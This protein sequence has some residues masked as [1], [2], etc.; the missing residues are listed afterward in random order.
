[1]V[2]RLRKVYVEPTTRCNLNCRTCMRRAWDEPAADMSMETYHRLLDSL[3]NLKTVER[4]AYWGIGEALMHPRIAEM[5]GRA[6]AMGLETELITNAQLLDE[7]AARALV[8]AGL[9]RLIV[10]VDGTTT[11]GLSEIRPGAALET[12]RAN[13][14]FLRQLRG[15]CGERTPEIAVEFVL[16]RKNL[17]QLRDLPRLA[18]E[19]GATT[20]Y[21]T[22]VLPYSREL[23][24][25]IL[26]ALSATSEGFSIR[27]DHHD[28]FVFP[29]IDARPEMLA[30]IRTLPVTAHGDFG[31][32]LF[33]F[34]NDGIACPFLERGAVVVRWDGAVSPCVEL[35]HSHQVYVLGREKYVKS[36]VV[37]RLAEQ[38]LK[39]IWQGRGYR[40]FRE[41]LRRF[42]FSPCVGCGGCYMSE[43]NE[44]DCIG[45]TFP[46][47]GDCLWARRV[48]LCP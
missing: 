41:R 31:H 1:M 20:V 16:M 25:E 27:F 28:G 33:L 26:Y 34:G 9:D 36:H 5:I 18:R 13:I 14:G 45:S 35:L 11:A 21:L 17:D 23:S 2:H 40:R 39:E 7:S 15:D 47:C 6:H 29:R 32:S 30:A 8:D 46:T 44:E 38:T 22:N 48:V 19:L 43:S 3:R 42:E 10:S 12:T 37:G 4:V 24:G